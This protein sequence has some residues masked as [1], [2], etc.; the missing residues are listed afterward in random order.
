M[1]II[2]NGIDGGIAK[3]I[4]DAVKQEKIQQIN[5][6][7]MAGNELRKKKS[8]LIGIVPKDTVAYG[9]YFDGTVCLILEFQKFV[10]NNI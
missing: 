10:S 5:T 4:G 9:V 8:T 3:L 6:E 2:T 1:W 7:I